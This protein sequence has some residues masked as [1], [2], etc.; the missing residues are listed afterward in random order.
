V[1]V[2]KVLMPKLSEAMESGKI[3]KWLKKEGDRVQAGDIL[4]EVETDK[5]DVEM[6][7]FGSGVLQIL[8]PAGSTVPV[9]SLIGVI[10]EA[11]DDLSALV[12]STS[13]GAGGGSA[14]P[15]LPTSQK[16]QEPQ[17]P[18]PE[19]FKL[20]AGRITAFENA[21]TWFTRWVRPPIFI[22]AFIGFLYL[23]VGFPIPPKTWDGRIVAFLWWAFLV[24]SLLTFLTASTGGMIASA[25]WKR[26]QS[27]YARV[28]MYKLAV[29][30]Y[31]AEY[32]AYEVE[33]VAWLKTQ[34]SW[35]DTL[36]PRRFEQEVAEFFKKQGNQ[37]EWTGRSGDGGV[38][39][40]LTTQNGKKVVVQCKAHG[41]PISP[42]AVRDL[43]GTLLHEKSDEA[44]LMSRSG[45]T[46]GARKFAEGKAIVLLNLDHVLPGLG[47]IV[48]SNPAPH[49]P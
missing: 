28:R 9:G 22:L 15:Q 12:A 13:H 25:L 42:G 39:L 16:P 18:R 23:L 29:G 5:A 34:R 1:A 24:A 38:D 27:D 2:S 43:Y 49:R 17:P 7:A 41:K 4:A 20:T 8:S 11:T 26:C 21:E 35:W 44:W 6:E 46:V 45:F 14:A 36:G 10:A 33:H 19:A 40:R 31:S 37:V 3:I 32:A 48:D 47:S 30:Q